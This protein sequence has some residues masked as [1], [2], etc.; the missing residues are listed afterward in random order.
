MAHTDPHPLAG[1][2]VK[3]KLQTNHPRL[4]DAGAEHSD[5]EVEDW[6]DSLTGS[7][8]R[9]PV[10]ANNFACAIYKVRIMFDH[11]ER[12]PV[13]DEVVY[14]KIRG[15]GHLVHVSELAA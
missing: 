12:V 7:S 3:I 15:M 9:S 8:W 10:M 13:D 1:E 14:G 5:F 6:W 2:T 11:K 4:G